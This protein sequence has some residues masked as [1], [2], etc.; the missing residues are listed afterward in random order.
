MDQLNV[1]R[2]GEVGKRKT[3]C[4]LE[5]DKLFVRKH[6]ESLEG[7]KFLPKGTS[8]SMAG[9]GIAWVLRHSRKSI[10]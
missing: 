4:F 10:F 1:K 9:P 3:P 5:G 8:Y 7:D 2:S 6:R